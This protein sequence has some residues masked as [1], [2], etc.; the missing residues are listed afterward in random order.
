MFL[1]GQMQLFDE[2]PLF[3]SF[4]RKG[5]ALCVRLVRKRLSLLPLLSLF[6]FA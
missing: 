1:A 4:L 2:L 6:P 5:R 3:L